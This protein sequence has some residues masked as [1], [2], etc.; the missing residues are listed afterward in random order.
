MCLLLGSFV[1]AGCSDSNESFEEQVHIQYAENSKEHYDISVSDEN[2]LTMA[3]VSD[4]EWTDY[5]GG[6]P[7]AKDRKILLQIP[8]A[9]LD[10]FTLSMT[11]E[12][13]SLPVLTVA[14]S[15][16][17]SSNGGNISFENLEVG[18]ALYLTAKNGDTSGTVIGS[19]DDF[20]IQTEIKKGDS[21]LPNNK[22]GGEKML[23][24]FSN[25]GNVKIEFVNK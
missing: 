18:N 25:N 8:D 17:I 15:I 20:A 11:N 24:V 5:V 6:K 22:E 4:K 9:L 13:I 16:S 23:N 14:G 21:N 7:S 2:V 1:L 19:Y 3:S 12:D 10:T